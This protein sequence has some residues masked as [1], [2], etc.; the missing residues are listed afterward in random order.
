MTRYLVWRLSLAVLVLFGV[1]LIVFMLLHLTGDPT[2]LLLPE[3]T[4]EEIRE[5]FRHEMGFDQP[6]S[7]Q[8]GKFLWKALQGDFGTSYRQRLP[9]MALVLE[10]LPRTYQLTFSALLIAMIVAIP[11]GVMAAVYR[12]T[13]VDTLTMGF[14]LI[15]QAT[16]TYWMGLLFIILFSVRLRWFPT[17]GAQGLES[18]VLPATTL[19][20]YSMARIARMTR[21]SM[22]E[23]LRTN[24]VRTARAKGLSERVVL[25]KHALRNAALPIVTILGLE[26]GGLLGGA[27]ITEMVFSWPGVGRLAVNAIHG[28]DYPVVQAVVFIIATTFVLLN[29]LTDLTYALLDP[30][31]RY[32]GKGGA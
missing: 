26:L 21:S 32:D 13:W 10:R 5:Q 20:L 22:L 6:L 28:H 16:P 7:V 9:A 2:A 1:S 30:R 29:L 19:G 8:Y 12:N 15:G 3:D 18:L 23:V 24:Y 14:S 4:P 11:A 31:I 27:V 17:G 25:Y